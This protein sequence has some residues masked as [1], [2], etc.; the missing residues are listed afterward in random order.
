MPIPK[1]V[2]KEERLTAKE[3][4]YRTLQQWI[5]DGVLEQLADQKLVYTIPSSGTYVSPIDEEDMRHVYVMMGE[6][7]AL[8]VRFCQDKIT[9]AVL[10]ELEELNEQFWKQANTGNAIQ[11]AE[12]D[13]RFHNCLCRLAGNPY[14]YEYANQL[15]IQIRRNENRF[16][17]SLLVLKKS[18]DTHGQIIQALREER[19][20][21]AK[22]LI[23][24]NWMVSTSIL[25]NNSGK[26]LLADAQYDFV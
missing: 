1:K 11:R 20:A 22:T 2:E 4:V 24:D 5:V 21:D 15:A 13:L 10:A 25:I 14:L 9:D 16:F 8:A 17:K 7:Q 18:Y 12:A 26:D 19:W 3:R 6:I 23:R